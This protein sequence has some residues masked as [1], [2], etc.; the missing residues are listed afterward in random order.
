MLSLQKRLVLALAVLLF[1]MGAASEPPRRLSD[2][3]RYAVQVSADFLARGPVAI[4]EE[5]STRSP[6]RKLGEDKAL[7]EIEVRTGPRDGAVWELRTVVP[8]LQDETAV[9]A[10][11]FPSGIDE[12][13][14]VS[15]AKEGSLYKIHELRILAEPSRHA[16]ASP[17]ADADT[18]PNDEPAPAPA[19]R[20]MLFAG[21]VAS[22][23]S[24]AAAMTRNRRKSLAT[25][26]AILAIFIVA[27]GVAWH[28]RSGLAAP[29]ETATAVAAIEPTDDLAPLLPLRRSMAATGG[30]EFASILA[31]MPKAGL[32]ADVSRLWKAQLALQEMSVDEVK[33]TLNRFK[34]P[35]RIP[36]VEVLRARLA[37]LN[38]EEVD[39]VMAYERAINL[40]PGHDGLWLEA[41]QA[42]YILGF[43]DRAKS[44]LERLSR[45]GSRA[46]D[47]YY[48]RAVLFAS[49]NDLDHAQELFL[50]G[51]KLRPVERAELFKQG[52]LWSMLRRPVV[53]PLLRLD[54]ASEPLVTPPDQP[55]R[56]IPLPAG[57]QSRIAAN[58]FR[59]AIGEQELLVPG[60]ADLA[61]RD[62]PLEDAG[63]WRRLEEE[64]ALADLPHLILSSQTA[65]A[66]TQ[67]LLRLK[68]QRAAK[69]LANRNRWDDLLLLTNGFSPR[70][71]HIPADLFFLRAHAL[72]RMERTAEVGTL[73]TSLATSRAIH[74]RNDPDTFLQ[75]GEMLVAVDQYDLA[76]KMFEKA[77]TRREIPMVDERIR[78]VSMDHRLATKFAQYKT[79]N[80]DIR[81][82]QEESEYFA[83]RVGEILEA[84]FQRLQQWIPLQS[85]KPVTV[86]VL[87]WE[88][89]RRIYTGTDF[90]LAFYDGK[91]RLPFAGLPSSIPEIVAI[92][93]HELAHAMIAQATNDQ[94]P[95]WFQEGLAQ[96]VE[97]ARYKTNVFADHEDHN[98]LSLP[99]VEGVLVGFP[100][101]T[102][103]QQSYLESFGVLQYIEARYGV[104]GIVRLQ[105][106]FRS[107]MTTEEAV[108]SLFSQS[109]EEFDRNAR[110]WGKKEAPKIWIGEI[111]RYDTSGNDMIKTPGKTA[112][113]QR[114]PLVVP[115]TFGKKRDD[116]WR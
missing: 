110:E 73:L 56:E 12:T 25:T 42:L 36:L 93:S 90:I 98:L 116:Q 89:F 38:A 105:Q 2:A 71:E 99:S 20:A 101:V 21:L 69:A 13:L 44:Y 52:V 107:G 27:G 47:V 39:A 16:L 14:I 57:S 35:T 78:Q 43:E 81:Y 45:M 53:F 96:K 54:S 51:W 49:K 29:D 115:E 109:L 113:E 33:M 11:N 5:L 77:A 9:F 75:L 65:G 58:F 32:A 63:A 8:S 97:M 46:A 82:P 86:H 60:G 64:R 84:E 48:L 88:E 61:A 114:K 31:T 3:E 66:L 95:K 76:V 103:I 30:K 68:V 40:G 108:K 102:M 106:A 15:L 67:P 92:L 111:K 24:V 23:A 72:R 91:L 19:N 18:T 37:F 55:R 80:F 104:Q 17:F 62:T 70:A 1:S 7:Q 100:E 41:A 79:T 87:S 74:R 94:S 112:E 50:R 28:V 85:F 4:L 34:P 26:L 59:V 10:I 83:R 22:S 6:L